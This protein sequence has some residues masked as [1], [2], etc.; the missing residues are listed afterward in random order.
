MHKL[1][2][3]EVPFVIL[4]QLHDIKTEDRS[5]TFSTEPMPW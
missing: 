1:K 2:Y 3:Y 5:Y 4:G